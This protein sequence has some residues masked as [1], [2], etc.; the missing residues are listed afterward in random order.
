MFAAQQNRETL[1]RA[2]VSESMNNEKP[3]RQIVVEGLVIVLSILLA[4][5]IDAWWGGQLEHETEQDSLE[6]LVRDLSATVDQL[7]ELQGFADGSVEA[8]LG[9]YT[10]LSHDPP[11]SDRAAVADQLSRSLAR[12]TVR[13]PR[14]GYSDLISTG[15]LGL[16]RD[17]GLR[18]SILKFYEAAELTERI[19][20]KN[21]A[22]YTDQRLG[23]VLLLEGLFL[24]R[25]VATGLPVQSELN[26]IIQERLG[27]DFRPRP[28]RLWDFPP[29]S[30]EWNRIRNALL[31]N[32]RGW[33]SAELLAGDLR[34]QAEALRREIRFYLGE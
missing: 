28:D 17:R 6:V 15:S 29:D 13:L 12:R 23:Q 20:E 2:G 5:G 22:L 33:Q 30:R 1:E 8:A 16:I 26:A 10:A 11:D 27:Q 34:S 24:P 18:E 21:S 7:G 4:F 9:A 19:I 31:M 14:A 32:A 25:P 3:S